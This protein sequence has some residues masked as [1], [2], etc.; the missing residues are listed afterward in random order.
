LDPP[1]AIFTFLVI[2]I[3]SDNI[4]LLNISVLV[5]PEILG[6]VSQVKYYSVRITYPKNT[7]SDD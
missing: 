7:P 3:N 4:L 2:V 5:N 1:F 6:S